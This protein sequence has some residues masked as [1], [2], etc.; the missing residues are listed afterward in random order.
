MLEWSTIST[1]QGSKVYS[2]DLVLLRC[3]PFFSFNSRI[4]ATVVPSLSELHPHDRRASIDS[5]AASQ[6][7]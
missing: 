4:L 2:V 1:H 3:L 7:P 6:R 5:A